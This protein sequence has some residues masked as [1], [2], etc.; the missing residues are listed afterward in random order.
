LARCMMVVTAVALLLAWWLA[1]LWGVC[2]EISPDWDC[3]CFNRQW[4]PDEIGDVPFH[5]IG[6]MV[7][8]PG[9]YL[10]GRIGGRMLAA[11]SLTLACVLWS[12]LFAD[13]VMWAVE[14][15]CGACYRVYFLVGISILFGIE[16]LAALIFAW[17]RFAWAGAHAGDRKREAEDGQ[18]ESPWCRK[19]VLAIPFLCGYPPK[20]GIVPLIHRRV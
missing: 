18:E 13:S 3:G 2:A 10:V 5:V 9:S 19:V 6:A 1:V 4:L 7:A 16:V 8:I 15:D 17:R 12:A 14:H 11:C 20:N